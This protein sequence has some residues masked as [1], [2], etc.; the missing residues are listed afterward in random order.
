MSPRGFIILLVATLL[1]VCAAV[2]MAVQPTISGA[3]SVAGEQMFPRLS[4]NPQDASRVTVQ[5]PQYTASWERRDGIWVSPERGDF[6][7]RAGLANDIVSGLARMTKVEA[8]TSKPEWYEYVRIGDP[9]A[10]PPTGVAHVTVTSAS[11]DILADTVLGARSYSI[12]ASHTR[13]GMFVRG[14]GDEQSWLVEGIASVPAGLPEW[15]DTLIDIPGPDIT[16]VTILEGDKTILH[17]R[18]TDL[19]NGVYAITH[20]DPAVAGSDNVANSNSLRSLASGIV[21]LRVDDVRAIASVS[22]GATAR[23][24]RFTMTSGMQ[25]DVTIFDVDGALWAIF[26]ATAPQGSAGEALA[27]DISARTKDW[28]FRLDGSRATRLNQPVVN[29]IQKP[30]EAGGGAAGAVPVPLGESGAPLFNPQGGSGPMPG[31]AVLPNF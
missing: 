1:A 12:A 26:K 25:L 21:G 15:F 2:V 4:Q 5:T 6:P 10:T 23:T 20:L 17:T 13:G 7:G 19:T 8:K 14:S 18:K 29:L 30:T 11:G 22:P 31:A 24:D 9:S 27:A 16:G 28:A 3:D